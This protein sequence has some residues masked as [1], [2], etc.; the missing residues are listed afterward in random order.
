MRIQELHQ[1]LL[2]IKENI[3]KLLN[4]SKCISEQRNYLRKYYNENK[5]ATFCKYFNKLRSEKNLPIIDFEN[6]DIDTQNK[7]ITELLKLNK[8]IIA[9]LNEELNAIDEEIKERNKINIG[10][11]VKEYCLITNTPFSDITITAE[12]DYMPTDTSDDKL[13]DK[14]VYEFRINIFN[15]KDKESSLI[16]NNKYAFRSYTVLKD[17]STIKDNI[18]VITDDKKINLNEK[19]LKLKKLVFDKPEL[20][21]VD[22]PLN[23]QSRSSK[24]FVSAINNLLDKNPTTNVPTK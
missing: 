19:T 14:Y 7:E 3:S 8:Q 10:D 9:K 22:H 4:E 23:A 11:A 13:K 24:D 16:Y 6:L 17:G 21:V 1:R 15:N 20:L 2:D 12:S 5:M 18:E